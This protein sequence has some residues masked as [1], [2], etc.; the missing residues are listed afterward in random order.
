MNFHIPLFLTTFL[1]F[2]VGSDSFSLMGLPPHVEPNQSIE[3]AWTR[4]YSDMTRFAILE[5][6]LP[7]ARMQDCYYGTAEAN[8]ALEGRVELKF[9]DIE[10][11]ITLAA[12][13]IGRGS[14]QDWMDGIA[15]TNATPTSFYVYPTSVTIGRGTNNLVGPEG[16]DATLSQD[17]RTTSTFDSS[18]ER[19]SI[20]SSSYVNS[21]P[22]I[23]SQTIDPQ[24]SSNSGKP[25]AGIIA[26]SVTGSVLILF[27]VLGWWYWR[28]K[29]MQK[30]VTRLSPFPYS[31]PDIVEKDLDEPGSIVHV[32]PLNLT[33]RREL[34]QTSS[35]VDLHLSLRV[36]MIAR[37]LA[38]LRM[39]ADGSQ[40][41][42]P[43]YSSQ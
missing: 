20:I 33:G 19:S 29:R 21:E 26:G 42:L 6:P 8:T 30:A 10:K 38:E 16:P 28:R 15:S 24:S 5:A 11:T 35:S 37:D 32:G 43:D 36:N 39:M 2:A 7:C 18:T 25:G 23:P 3:V 31:A 12:Y 40:E 22:A 14:V 41:A 17:T 13:D 9:K 34:G 1:F 27:L 4:Q